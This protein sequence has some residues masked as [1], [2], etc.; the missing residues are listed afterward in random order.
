M[1]SGS[2]IRDMGMHGYPAY[3]GISVPMPPTAIGC[4]PIMVGRGPQI[5]AGAGRPFTMDAGPL[6]ITMAGFG[7][8]ARYG[9]RHG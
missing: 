4:I 7:Y 6:T 9:H 5:T 2:I 3:P 8:L 1:D